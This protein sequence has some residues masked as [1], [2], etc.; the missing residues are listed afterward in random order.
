MTP[1]ARIQA[2]IEIL[3]RI[4]DGV[5]AEKALTNWTRSSRFAGSKDRAA[6]RDHVFDVLRKWRST[7]IRG[8]AET[9]RGR[10][11]GLLREQELDLGDFFSGQGHAPLALTQDE[12]NGGELPQD[13]VALDLPDWLLPLW[14]SSLGDDAETVARVMRGRAD[15]FL[16]VNLSKTDITAAQ[17]ALQKDGIETEPHSLSPTALHVVSNP[18]RVAQSEAYKNGLVE[19]QDTASQAVVDALPVSDGAKVLDF[20]AGGGGKALAMAARVRSAKIDAHDK[21]PQRM[22]DLPDRAGRAGANVNIVSDPQSQYDLVFCDVPCS[23]SGAWRRTPEGK[24]RL[25]QEVLDDTLRTQAEI[26][27]DCAALVSPGGHLAYATC[28]LLKCENQDQIENFLLNN[29]GF[30]R[31]VQRQYTPLDGGDGFFISILEKV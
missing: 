3:D 2:A 20:C 1:A 7:A 13:S 24:W 14:R 4:G 8:G 23:G 16:R 22:K 15:V 26:L 5:P 10:M 9:G 6:I 31:K 19:L 25:T 28:S 17:N 29:N 18:R 12:E 21:F 27:V 30:V 11:I